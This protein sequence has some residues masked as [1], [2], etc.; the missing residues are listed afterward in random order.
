MIAPPVALRDP[1]AEPSSMKELTST[2]PL[3]PG[4]AVS[5][6]LAFEVWNHVPLHKFH[7]S[8]NSSVLKT[9][10]PCPA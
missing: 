9:G 2:G 7:A 10:Q 8:Q 1:G 6:T 4:S 5:L 3:M